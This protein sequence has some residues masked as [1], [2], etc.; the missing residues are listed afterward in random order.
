[1][2]VALIGASG[3]VG[4]FVLREALARGYSVTAIV[5][6]VHRLVPQ[7]NLAV[8]QID[9]NDT[10]VLAEALAGH[11]A[12]ISAFSPG[13]SRDAHLLHMEGVVSILRAVRRSGVKRVLFVGG[14]GSLQVKPGTEL[15]DTPD[16]PREYRATALATR[17]TLHLL[18]TQHGLDWTFLSPAAELIPAERTGKFRLGGDWLLTDDRGRSSI[19]TQDYA[20]ALV[21]ELELPQHT[22]RRFS[23]AY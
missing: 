7:S 5:R 20:M 21:N 9:V 14:A 6:N 17:E 1:M 8:R 2:R 13:H 18:T 4:S 19:S 10:V 11:D 3:F 12:V 23:V 16:F 22:G 15:V